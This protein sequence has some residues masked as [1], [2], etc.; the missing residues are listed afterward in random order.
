MDSFGSTD[1]TC[2]SYLQLRFKSV[3]T[4]AFICALN[5]EKIEKWEIIKEN[6]E[7]QEILETS[8]LR[9]LALDS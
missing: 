6:K 4:T 2:A 9:S 1:C 8:S 3:T 5:L 7:I